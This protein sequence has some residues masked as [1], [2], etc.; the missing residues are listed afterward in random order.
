MLSSLSNKQL[1][2]LY[3]S[4]TVI[5]F[6]VNFNREIINVNEGAGWDGRL[7][8]KVTKTA[9]YLKAKALNQYHIQRVLV[10]LVVNRIL[11][12]TKS[13]KSIPEI[14]TAY[15]FFNLFC[16][17]L[18]IFYY[19]KIAIKLNLSKQNELIG[20]CSI[21]WIYPILKLL[22]YYPMLTDYAAFTLGLI[23]TYYYLKDSLVGML[24]ILLLGS[25]VYPT[26]SI[27]LIL[28]VFKRNEIDIKEYKGWLQ[29]AIL[30]S[31]FLVAIIGMYYFNKARLFSTISDTSPVTEI[32]FP[33][34]LIGAAIYLFY[35]TKFL[36]R[37]KKLFFSFKDLDNKRVIISVIFYLVIWIVRKALSS[38]YT[39]LTLKEF[40]FNIS[41]QSITNPLIF[42][43]A[44]TVYFGLFFMMIYYFRK[45]LKDVIRN[46]GFGMTY[47]VFIVIIFSLGNESRQLLNFYPLVAI[48]LIM[49]IQKSEAKFSNFSLVLYLVICLFISSFWATLS[50]NG[51]MNAD[52]MN[53]PA[54][55][56]FRYQGPW[57]SNYNYIIFSSIFLIIGGIFFVLQKTG[58]LVDRK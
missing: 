16:L 35:L 38:K 55:N 21:F 18:A 11:W 43:I 44:H 7:Y 58:K 49:A 2:I 46:F 37:I 20:F 27:F 23:F 10:P 8:L 32:L 47:W 28:I 14:I 41:K 42:I 1:R 45:Q 54:Q 39:G 57:M 17:L 15:R 36:P 50:W 22:F 29:S 12:I 34:S 5:I 3:I 40:L 19:V 9:Y 56:Y 4:I 26:F 53:Y 13:N 52:F 24:T 25:F 51:E 48:I 33:V 6:F 30:P 31:L